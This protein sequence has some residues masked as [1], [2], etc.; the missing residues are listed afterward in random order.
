MEADDQFGEEIDD[1]DDHHVNGTNGYA[2]PSEAAP[3]Y[4]SPVAAR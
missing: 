3:H 2:H 1:D 4:D